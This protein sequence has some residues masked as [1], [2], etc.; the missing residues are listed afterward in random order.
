VVLDACVL[1]SI[2]LTNF[3]MYLGEE[4]LFRAKWTDDIH[5]EWI[6]NVLK[7][8]SHLTRDKLERRR[9]LMDEH[10]LDALVTDYRPLIP[11]LTAI[12]EKDRHVLA[13]AIRAQASAIVTINLDDFPE[14]ALKP[15]DIEPLHPDDFVVNQ[16][17]LGSH[18]ADAVCA[19]ARNHRLSLRNPAYTV[20]QYI[21]MMEKAGLNKTGAIFSAPS[22]RP[23]L[24]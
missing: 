14:A 16:Y 8:N 12:N 19:A 17:S 15:W 5:E 6:R 21:R 23:K 2:Q 18:A 4:G 20:D 7:K 1:Y 22:V 24:E 10:A 9:R 3:F 11:T 13:A